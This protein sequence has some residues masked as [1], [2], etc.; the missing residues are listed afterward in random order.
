MSYKILPMTGMQQFC[1]SCIMCIH[2]YRYL[3]LTLEL[4]H[5]VIVVIPKPHNLFYKVRLN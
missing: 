2:D 4:V 5:V 3:S 1:N